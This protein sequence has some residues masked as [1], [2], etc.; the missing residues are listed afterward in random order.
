[1]NKKILKTGAIVLAAVVCSVLFTQ[2]ASAVYQ[3]PDTF[4]PSNTSLDLDFTY[5]SPGQE[6]KEA[7]ANALITILQILSGSLLYF[8]APLAV[9]SIGMTA[10]NLAMNSGNTEKVEEAKKQLTWLILGLVTIILAYSLIAFLM[11][12]VIGVFS[13]VPAPGA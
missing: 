1:M 10:F 6:S 8:V 12:F 2:M 11:D 5:T 13:Q 9:L 4:K 7:G 3:I